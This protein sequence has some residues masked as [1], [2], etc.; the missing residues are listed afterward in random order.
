[1]NKVRNLIGY[2]GNPPNPKWPKNSNIAINFVINVEEG[3]EMSPLY[4]DEKS[5][6]G[7]SEVPGGRHKKNQR[8][9]CHNHCFPSRRWLGTKKTLHF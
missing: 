2:G 4:G 9:L 8:D 5:E 3:S 6:I 1:M 7:I